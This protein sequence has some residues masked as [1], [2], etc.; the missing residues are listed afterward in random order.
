MNSNTKKLIYAVFNVL[1]IMLKL[2]RFPHLYYKKDKFSVF[3]HAHQR[4]IELIRNK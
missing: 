4:T 2:A 1:N 3:E